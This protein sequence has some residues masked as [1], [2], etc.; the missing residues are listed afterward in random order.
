MSDKVIFSDIE[1]INEEITKFKEV[2]SFERVQNLFQFVLL[3]DK[4]EEMLVCPIVSS[5]DRLCEILST[6]VILYMLLYILTEGTVNFLVAGFENVEIFTC[7]EYF[8]LVSLQDGRDVL[9]SK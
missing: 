3:E 6:N 5:L 1:E 2:V 9:R 4:I 8:L 7:D